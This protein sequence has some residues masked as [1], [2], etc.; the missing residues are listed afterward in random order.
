[1]SRLQQ[2]AHELVW[3]GVGTEA[4][5]VAALGDDAHH[6]REISVIEAPPR[7][8]VAALPCA[9]VIEARR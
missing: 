1:M 8:V 9:R 3:K 4:P 2:P 7:R 6:G 5:D